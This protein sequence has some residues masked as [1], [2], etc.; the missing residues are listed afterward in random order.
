MNTFALVVSLI[1]NIVGI[2][3]S[4]DK[5]LLTISF[6]FL[7]CLA[8]G[9]V[10]GGTYL[11][12][13]NYRKRFPNFGNSTDIKGRSKMLMVIVGTIPGMWCLMG[14][15]LTMALAF[16]Q[17]VT[18]GYWSSHWMWGGVAIFGLIFNLK[19]NERVRMICLGVILLI[20]LQQSMAIV[21]FTHIH[22]IENAKGVVYTAAGTIATE[23][24]MGMLGLCQLKR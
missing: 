21:F 7:T 11:L 4:P 16:G 14:A 2:V 5:L 1:I 3:L 15:P 10:Y 17:D 22:V 6:T 8:P 20:A 12:K 24:F 9:C 23:L 18:L 19:N 13:K